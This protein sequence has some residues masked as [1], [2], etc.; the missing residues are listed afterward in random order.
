M[1]MSEIV[2]DLCSNPIMKGNDICYCTCRDE[3]MAFYKNNLVTR[4]WS[5]KISKYCKLSK[6][7][8]CEIKCYGM[9]AGYEYVH[10]AKCLVTGNEVYI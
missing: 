9:A 7:D 6:K 4:G 3:V 5:H 8:D 2:N 1:D 10:V